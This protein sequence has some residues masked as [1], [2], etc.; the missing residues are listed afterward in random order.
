MGGKGTSP[1]QYLLTRLPLVIPMVFILLTLVFL[2]C[3]GRPGR[4][5]LRVSR[6]QG[7]AEEVERIKAELGYDRPL[8]V[9]Y[10]EYLGDV[11]AATS[12][13]PSP[14]A[15]P[16]GTSSGQRRGDARADVLRDDR[17]DRRR[18]HVRPSRRPLPGHVDRRRRPDVRDPHLRHAGLLPRLMAQLLRLV[19]GWLPTSVARARSSTRRSSRTHEHLHDRHA[20]RSRLGRIRRRR[21]APDPAGGHPWSRDGRCLHPPDPHQR[22]PDDEGR[23]HRGRSGARHRRALRRL[24]PRLPKRPRACDH[25]RGPTVALPRARSTETTF[26]WPGIGKTLTLPR[27]PRLPAVQGIIIVFA[28]VVVVVSVVI[29]FVNAYIDPRIR[30]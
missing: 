4:S 6:G 25:G 26:N 13:S 8:Y 27:E 1:R 2:L 21:Q 19:L 17:R 22:H 15:A 18:G 9:Q 14:T 3:E 30:Y 23:L 20:H 29:D 7:A 11:A 10:A 12:A 28:L 5:D 24:P 16:S